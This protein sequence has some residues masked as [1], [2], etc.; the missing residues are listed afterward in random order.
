[1]QFGLSLGRRACRPPSTPLLPPPPSRASTCFFTL[2]VTVT[3]GCVLQ[4]W[5]RDAQQDPDG[6]LRSVQSPTVGVTALR[7]ALARR[8]VPAPAVSV[9]RRGAAERS[10]R[11]R[12][13]SR[14]PW[15][16]STERSSLVWLLDSP[17]CCPP[18]IHTP[19]PATPTLCYW[20]DRILGA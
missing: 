3:R 7:S 19:S 13:D 16:P 17:D 2:C 9:A 12:A 11:S 5:P 18:R 8:W 4:K 10:A 20:R 14:A 15:R 6:L 1:M